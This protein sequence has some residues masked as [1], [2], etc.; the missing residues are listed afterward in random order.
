MAADGLATL[1]LRPGAGDGF[2]IAVVGACGDAELNPP[3]PDR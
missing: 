3:R 1:T 2:R